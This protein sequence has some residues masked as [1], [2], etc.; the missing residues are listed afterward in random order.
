[1]TESYIETTRTGT[2]TFRRISW[3]AVFAGVVITLV[4]QA[5][6]TLLG[7]GIGAA[8]VEPLQQS[9]PG[10]GLGIGAAIWFLV[11]TL[12]A[13]YI[14]AMVAG[15][16]SGAVRKSDRTLHGI[17]TWGTAAIIGVLSLTTAAGSLLGGAGS[18]VGGAATAAGTQPA[19]MSYSQSGAQTQPGALSPTGREAGYPQMDE[20]RAREAG[21]VA[22][23]RV[24]QGAFWSFV[25]LLLSGVVAGFGAITEKRVNGEHRT[26]AESDRAR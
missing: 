26:V 8:K 22:A 19:H 7:I 25:V 13:V 16:M 12:I 21:D 2:G 24:S 17:L 5:L 1:M 6:L 15:K 20:Q 9:N 23:K 3:A 11:S 14:G 4:I 18:L 10:R